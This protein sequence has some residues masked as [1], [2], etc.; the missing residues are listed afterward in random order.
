MMGRFMNICTKLVHAN[1]N[2]W[3]IILYLCV[4]CVCCIKTYELG[5]KM[6]NIML[7]S[8]NIVWWKMFCVNEEERR[9]LYDRI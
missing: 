3:L 2:L 9:N 4:L 1:L 5:N 8:T 7:V 6:I